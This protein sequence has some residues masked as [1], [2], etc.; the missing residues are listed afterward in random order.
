MNTSS[1]R[2]QLLAQEGLGGGFV[3]TNVKKRLKREQLKKSV[4][5]GLALVSAALSFIAAIIT[6]RLP[7][8]AWVQ[9]HI[10]YPESSGFAFPTQSPNEI[11]EIFGYCALGFLALGVSMLAIIGLR[12]W[13]RQRRLASIETSLG[14]PLEVLNANRKQK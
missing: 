1:F 9:R 6:Q 2:E 4:M 10:I 11:R 13:F 5:T 3:P 8:F 7:E 12:R 14:S